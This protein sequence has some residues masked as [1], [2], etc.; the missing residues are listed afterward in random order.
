MFQKAILSTEKRVHNKLL[1]MIQICKS[2]LSDVI[3]VRE[4]LLSKV[5]VQLWTY[6][7]ATLTLILTFF[8]IFS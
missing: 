8:C 4:N 6:K 7:K 5:L 3:T 2:I 1:I